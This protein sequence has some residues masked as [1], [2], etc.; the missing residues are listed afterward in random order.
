MRNVLVMALVTG[1]AFRTPKVV[2]PASIPAIAAAELDVADVTFTDPEGASDPETTAAAR[3]DI[4]SIL[5]RAAKAR[6]AT[7]GAARFR[8]RVV[9]QDRHD[10]YDS[11]RVDGL[12]VIGFLFA[13]F[14][15]VLERE[16]LSVELTL[17]SGGQTLVGHGSANE[18]GSIYVSA[19]RKALAIALRRAL[20]DA[21][22]P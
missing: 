21:R 1:C 16:H 17:E 13:P 20:T 6:P 4:T 22:P 19:R 3:C 2:M 18:S 8:V 7:T 14:G 5:I 12:A 10:I 9:L 11:M 15:M